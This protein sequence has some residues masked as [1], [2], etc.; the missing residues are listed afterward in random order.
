MNKEQLKIFLRLKLEEIW[1]PTIFVLI[2]LGLLFISSHYEL[3]RMYKI[4]NFSLLIIVGLGF[5]FLVGYWLVS[6]VKSNWEEAGKILEK[7]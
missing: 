7:R 4:L 2:C 1:F 5:L 6:F 3:D